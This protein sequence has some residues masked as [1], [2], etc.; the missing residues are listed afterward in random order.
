MAIDLSTWVPKRIVNIP[1]EQPG[2]SISSERWIELWTLHTEQGDDTA[3]AV[4]EILDTLNETAWHPT[5]AAAEISNPAIYTN[6]ATDV[7]GQLTELADAMEGFAGLVEDEQDRID[8]LIANT[9]L[10]AGNAL[11]LGGEL[12]AHYAL[13]GDLDT[14]EATVA[15]LALGAAEAIDH[16]DISARNIADAHPT[17]AI[18]G[19]DTALGTI[20]TA[21]ADFSDKNDTASHTASAVEYSTGISVA[22]KIAALEATIAALTGDMS[23]I[24]HND[25]ATR[26][27]SDAHPLDS[28]T[29]LTT[30]LAAKQATITGAATTIDTENLTA[31]MALVSDANGKVAAHASVSATE[32]GYLDGA[33]S[34]L[35]T[36]LDAKQ[37]TITA[38]T[39]D[40]TGGADGDVYIKYA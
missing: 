32:L 36:Q 31:S 13:A 12:P 7:S 14:L 11:K 10:S 16:N 18:T 37:K 25:L 24:D 19:L 20:P 8:D 21:H 30:A 29:G 22:Q 34:A 39:A 3:D 2:I 1:N 40:P 27:A 6:G 38:G 35:Q 17:S 23:E 33:T 9:T 4:K 15:G 26:D 28:I 5:D